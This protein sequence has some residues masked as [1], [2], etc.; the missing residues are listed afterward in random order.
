MHIVMDFEGAN[1]FPPP[2]PRLSE[3]IGAL[4][5]MRFVD[6]KT[7]EAITAA[8]P[9]GE[10]WIIDLGYRDIKESWVFAQYLSC[11]RGMHSQISPFAFELWS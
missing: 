11:Y 4:N 7:N 10:G 1:L 8:N 2:T 5:D 9:G 3:A 6:S